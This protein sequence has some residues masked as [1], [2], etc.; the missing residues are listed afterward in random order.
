MQSGFVSE[1]TIVDPH[2]LVDPV[3]VHRSVPLGTGYAGHEK[4]D[5]EYVLSRRP[6]YVWLAN[7]VTDTPLPLSRL[8]DE[9]WGSFNREMVRRAGFAEIYEYRSVPMSQDHYINLHVRKE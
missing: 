6:T 4:F 2:G 8:R 1:L 5:T 7:R 9:V 3:I